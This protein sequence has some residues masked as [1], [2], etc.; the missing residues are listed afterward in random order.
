MADTWGYDGTL[1]LEG[2]APFTGNDELDRRVLAGADRVVVLPTADAFEQPQDLVALAQ[3]WGERIGVEVE[4]LMVITRPQADA[5][6]AA[7]VDAAPAVFLAGDSSNHLRSVLKGTPLFESIV[8]VL[9][10]GGVVMAAAASASALCDPM[11]D[12]RGGAFALGLGIVG[13]LAIMTE[14]ETW[15]ADQLGRARGLANTPLVE[16]PTGSALVRTTAGWETVGAP[17]LH[18]ELP[19]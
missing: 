11:T 4:P 14:T 13:G 8:R 7:V 9:D 12:R 2:G 3:A 6:A 1:V 17:V 19:T 10:R 5:D 18:G 15:P 16:L